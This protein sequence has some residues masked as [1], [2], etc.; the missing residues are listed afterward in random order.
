MGVE[1]N[2]CLLRRDDEKEEE[3]VGGVEGGGVA[4]AFCCCCPD[5]KGMRCGVVPPLPIDE[6]PLVAGDSDAGFELP[7]PLPELVGSEGQKPRLFHSTLGPSP[8]L[9]P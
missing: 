9:L 6:C 2:K 4:A 3:P 5:R 8:W 7:P 1:L